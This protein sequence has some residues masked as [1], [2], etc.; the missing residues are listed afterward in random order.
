MKKIMFL[1]V[2]VLLG[3]CV[4]AQEP[5]PINEAKIKKY[6]PVVEGR[7]EYAEVVKLDST[8]TD[9]LLFKNARQWLVDNFKSGKDV[10]QTEDKEGGYIIGQG[11]FSMMTNPVSL[12]YSNSQIWFSMKIEVK[13][14]RY[15]YT[16]YDIIYKYTM[17]MGKTSADLDFPLGQYVSDAKE[18][19]KSMAFYVEVDKHL[20]IRQFN[21]F[22]AA[23]EP[24]PI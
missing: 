21:S 24:H 16:F 22:I 3:L 13:D 18:T 5:L 8:Y 15:R 10:L 20:K 12:F 23:I 9:D 17:S 7:V 1:V 2:I 11:F 6:F 19:K 14:G 4:H